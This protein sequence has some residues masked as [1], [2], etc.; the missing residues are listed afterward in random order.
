MTEM[1]YQVVLA[2]LQQSQEDVLGLRK[3][4]AAHDSSALQG[5]MDRMQ[6]SMDD[7]LKTLRATQTSLKQT[8]VALNEAT[9][10]NRKLSSEMVKYMESYMDE[11][12][13][14]EALE[15]EILQ[16]KKLLKLYQSNGS[17]SEQ[18]KIIKGKHFGRSSEKGKAPSADVD[19]GQEEHDFD[20]TNPPDN[21]DS[22]VE[23]AAT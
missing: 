16:M 20:G 17:A 3:Q 4:L 18:V 9:D 13:R 6:A 11:R 7:M 8:Q 23:P 10:Q 5:S 14:R 21:M 12:R 15:S 2:L 19:R 22:V 1:D